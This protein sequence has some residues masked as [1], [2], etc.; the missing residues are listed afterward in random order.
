MRYPHQI[1]PVWM[2]NKIYFLPGFPP[3]SHGFQPPIGHQAAPPAISAARADK[4]CPKF[5][6]AGCIIHHPL[7][8][9][10][11]IWY[12]YI[13]N[14]KQHIYIYIIYIWN[15]KY[16]IQYMNIY[17][18]DISHMI[19]CISY[20]NRLYNHIIYCIIL[21]CIM[22]YCIILYCIILNQIITY[23]YICVHNS[24][25]ITLSNWI[26]AILNIHRFCLYTSIYNNNKTIITLY[27]YI[28]VHICMYSTIYIYR[29]CI[30]IRIYIIYYIIYII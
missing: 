7:Q 26:I 22:L 16:D 24:Y 11:H 3:K 23:I 8:I 9:K 10:T 14:I 18:Y 28:Y 27:I 17:I 4:T 30:C 19:S 21:C 15:L 12:S 6:I 2:V 5:F 29:M 20:T 25:S 1:F 13:V